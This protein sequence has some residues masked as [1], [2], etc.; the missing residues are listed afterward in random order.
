MPQTPHH[1]PYTGIK[2]GHRPH[3]P[4]TRGFCRHFPKPAVYG[5]IWEARNPARGPYVLKA[6]ARQYEKKISYQPEREEQMQS[7]FGLLSKMRSDLEKK[8]GT[9]ADVLWLNSVE[10]STKAKLKMKAKKASGFHGSVS[11]LNSLAV[12]A[13]LHANS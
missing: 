1:V 11:R 9:G 5:G 2:G 13:E 12:A 8:G 4:A 10:T 6:L 3:Q 7:L